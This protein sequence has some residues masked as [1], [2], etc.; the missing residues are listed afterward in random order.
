MSIPQSVFAIVPPTGVYVR[1]DRC[2]TPLE[3]FRTIA[4]RPPIDLMYAAGAFEQAGAHCALF[5]YPA[6][7]LGWE[8]LERDL[9]VFH[10]DVVVLS[11][12]TQTVEADMRAAAL[13]KR[14]C[15]GV[16]TVA[17][18]AHFNTR[19]I[20]VLERHP[21]LDVALREEIEE[22]CGEIAAGRRFADIAGIT[23]RDDDGR[24]VRNAS[25]GFSRE[26]DAMAFPAR[27]LTNNVLYVRPDTGRPQT[28][29]ITNRG[30]PY[31]CIYCLANQV[32]GVANR[33]RSVDNVI[34]EIRECIDRHGIDDFLFRSDLFTQNKAWV[35][36]FCSTIVEQGLKIEWA[37]NSRVDTVDEEILTAMRRAGCWIIAFG[38]ESGDQEALDRMEKKAKVEDAFTAVDLCRRVGIKSSVYLL[39]GLPW[40]DQAAVDR[41]VE[42]ARR[43]DP[44]ILEFFYPYPF[45][46]TALQRECVERG[47]LTQDEIPVQSYAEPA[48]ATEH[49]SKEELKEARTLALRRFYVRPSKV[50]RTLAGARSLSELTNYLRVGISQLR[51][52]AQG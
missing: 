15:P 18:G 39:L 43:L 7:G 50:A 44:D 32:A 22:A 9:R 1:E 14:V 19:D 31:H 6:E 29:L 17:K 34:A 5:D 20:D 24:I 46:G 52:L 33:Y 8:D 49:L 38:V 13:A 4:M 2:Q 23:W 21:E 51:L 37:C 16:I 27:H 25:R 3:K 35:L 45:P 41:Q 48:F 26:L 36:E 11:V 42:F 28:T 30:C 10:P 47:L 40:D 12:T